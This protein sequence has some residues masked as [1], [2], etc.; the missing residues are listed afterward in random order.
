MDRM[1]YRAILTRNAE[2][3]LRKV[4]RHVV[5]KLKAWVVIVEK[6]GLEETRKI[7]GFHDEPLSGSQHGKRS[8]R[9]SKAYRAICEIHNDGRGPVA[10]IKE[11]TKHEY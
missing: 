2:K 6:Q 7:P 4:P 10:S 1:I 3:Q 5:V 11:V 9:L 8:I